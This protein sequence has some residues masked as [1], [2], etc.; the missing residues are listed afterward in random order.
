MR[1]ESK[2]IK[3]GGAACRRGLDGGTLHSTAL[4]WDAVVLAELYVEL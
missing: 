3:D 4:C 2:Q 1:G